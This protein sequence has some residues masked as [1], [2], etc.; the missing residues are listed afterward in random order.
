MTLRYFII[1]KETGQER[2][3][4][5]ETLREYFRLIEQLTGTPRRASEA[6]GDDVNERWRMRNGSIARITQ[7][8]GSIAV[9]TIDSSDAIHSWNSGKT[10]AGAG[11]DLVGLIASEQPGVCP[12]PADTQ[13]KA[14][15]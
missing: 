9:G 11:Y 3:C 5:T 7:R 4:P 6:F 2:E 12:T 15:G 1:V 13:T 14:D 8:L 10:A